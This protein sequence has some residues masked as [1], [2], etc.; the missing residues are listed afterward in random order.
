[1]ALSPGTSTFLFASNSAPSVSEDPEVLAGRYRE[2]APAPARLSPVFAAL[3]PAEKCAYVRNALT[4]CRVPSLNLDDRPI[5][6]FLGSRLLGWSTGG[7]IDP[8]FA[9]FAHLSLPGI[10]AVLGLPFLVSFLWSAIR[11]RRNALLTVVVAAAA[12]GFAG[13][14]FEITALFVFQNAWGYVYQA[15]G[16]LI[17]IFMMGLGTGA[18][19]TAR[20]IA[21]ADPPPARAARLLAGT[22]LLTSMG[23][24][25]FML[26]R[27]GLRPA[28][29]GQLLLAAWLAAMGIL[30]GAV[31]PLGMRVVAPLPA[32]RG[33]GM[34]N[35][36]DYLG[37]AAGSILTAAFFM[38]LLGTTTSLAIVAMLAALAAALLAFAARSGAL[39][40]RG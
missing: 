27:H 10:L 40:R 26:L 18:A 33:G 20:R 34:L 29:P 7:A 24:A 38:P 11:P 4:T 30:A 12:G 15:V 25:A 32:A 5:A 16:L 9:W 21:K 28:W 31:L 14:S 19:W 23:A 6:Y 8:L 35:A 37:G 36:G 1:V 2:S 22:L 17:A 3:Y 39:G 13:L